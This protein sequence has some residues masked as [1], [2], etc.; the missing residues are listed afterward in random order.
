MCYENLFRFFETLTKH[1]LHQI[2]VCKDKVHVHVSA[3]GHLYMY[4]KLICTFAGKERE[5]RA[6]L[7]SLKIV[8]GSY[9]IILS[10]M[11][12]RVN[13]W[14]GLLLIYVCMREWLKKRTQWRDVVTDLWRL[15]FCF[16]QLRAVVALTSFDTNPH[17]VYKISPSH[18]QKAMG[19]ERWQ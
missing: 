3:P 4:S 16:L 6:K 13:L 18:S 7:L 15:L 14:R 2:Y 17:L 1:I 8:H 5:S 19:E 10:C 12:S 11:V 9:I